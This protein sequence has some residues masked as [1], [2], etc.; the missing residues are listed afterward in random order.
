MERVVERALARPRMAASV[1]VGLGARA[2][3]IAVVGVYGVLSYRVSQRVREFAVRVAL[4]ARPWS[5][6][7][8]VLREGALVMGGGIAVGLSLAPAATQ[9]LNAVVFGVDTTDPVAYVSSAAV[10][11]FTTAAACLIPANKAG[12]SDPMAVLRNE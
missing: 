5:I 2:L 8:L 11:A 9:A 10:L 1:A 6:R 3:V 4:G 12:R 7:R